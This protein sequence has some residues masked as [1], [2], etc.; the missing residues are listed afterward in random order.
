VHYPDQERELTVRT[1]RQRIAVA[2]F[3]V[4][5]MFVVAWGAVLVARVRGSVDILPSIAVF[6]LLGVVFLILSVGAYQGWIWA[7]WIA[8][9]LLGSQ[10]L[11]IIGVIHELFNLST[12]AKARNIQDQFGINPLVSL[13][14][15]L[16][17]SILGS[18]LFVWLLVS[19]TQI[20]KPP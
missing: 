7:R 1:R 19:I 13:G 4:L 6:G 17:M 5:A 18:G 8:L 10:L 15:N 12:P 3:F 9:V 16:T 2:A 11:G 20:T 14:L